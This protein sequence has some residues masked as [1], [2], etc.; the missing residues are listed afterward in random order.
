M[1]PLSLAS[2]HHHSW[3]QEANNTT[4]TPTQAWSRRTRSSAQHMKKQAA[5]SRASCLLSVEGFCT[6]ESEPAKRQDR[7]FCPDLCTLQTRHPVCWMCCISF[8]LLDFTLVCLIYSDILWY[9]SDKTDNKQTARAS[10]TIMDA[11]LSA[12]VHVSLNHDQRP[13]G[14]GSVCCVVT[15]A[16][17]VHWLSF[18]PL[19]LEGNALVLRFLTYKSLLLRWQPL[20]S[21]LQCTTRRRHVCHVSPALSKYSTLGHELAAN[22]N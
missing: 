19:Q 13:T 21:W 20:Q 7:A 9:N 10:R 17:Y 18:N 6:T 16:F 15:G 4:T 5:P 11:V 8:N 2:I 14:T 22:M 1:K 12:C 3:Q